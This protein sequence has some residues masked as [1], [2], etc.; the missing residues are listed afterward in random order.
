MG[1]GRGFAEE[2]LL[3]ANQV[4]GF[5]L[6]RICLEGPEEELKKTE[7]AQP[8]IFV[9][10]AAAFHQLTAH[11]SLLTAD[12]CAVAGHS[13]GEYS[14]LYAAGSISFEDGIRILNLRGRYMQ[15]AV[16][17][18]A[19]AMMAVLGL[20]RDKIEKCCLD[21]GEDV[22][23]ANF[24]SPG[25]VVIS[26]ESSAVERAANLC[27][28]AGAKRVIPL[29]VSAP[30]HCKLMASAQEK[31]ARE[32]EKIKITD[33]QIPVVANVN[34]E[35]VTSADK[36]KELLIA[37]VTAPVLWEDSIKRMVADGISEFIEVGPG[38]VL[39]GLIKKIN[40]EVS[41]K[42]YEEVIK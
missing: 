16:P 8:A 34:A 31:L 28:K 37:Q 6:K 30:F 20:D 36:I 35:Y 29:Q 12:L 18:G 21:A 4:L 25:Q 40:P 24:N 33:A 15:E 13:L 9:I 19:G 23:C 5:N 10:S 32:I 14:A 27:K 7:I 42:S 3:G 11:R 17:I 39:A 38:K 2:L 26:G 1:M 41:V 22:S